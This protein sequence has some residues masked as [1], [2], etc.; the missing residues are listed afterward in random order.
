MLTRVQPLLK[1]QQHCYPIQGSTEFLQGNPCNKN[2]IS[3]M[4]TGF[5]AMK[6]Y[7]FAVKIDFQGVFFKSYR[8]WGVCSEVTDI[9]LQ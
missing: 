8:V 5:P 4:R 1:Q 7:F 2:R 9:S 6:T 3:A